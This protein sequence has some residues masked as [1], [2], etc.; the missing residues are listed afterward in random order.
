M[1]L[2]TRCGTKRRQPKK[3]KRQHHAGSKPFGHDTVASNHEFGAVDER[4]EKK[5]GRVV[6]GIKHVVHR[7]DDFEGIQVKTVNVFSFKK[8]Y[9]FR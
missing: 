7:K 6:P 2:L 9:I 1:L 3:R 5:S 8:I 4:R